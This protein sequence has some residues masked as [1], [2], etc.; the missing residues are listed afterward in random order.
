ESS[1]SVTRRTQSRDSRVQLVHRQRPTDNARGSNQHARGVDVA[2]D[3][4]QSRHLTGVRDAAF[5]H[6]NIRTPRVRDNPAG[7]SRLDAFTGDS[8]GCTANTILREDSTTRAVTV[9]EQKPDVVTRLL[10]VRFDP[11]VDAIGHPAE[12]RGDG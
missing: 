2:G 10:T 11:R 7:Y 6:G 9:R 1:A 3:R 8:D 4:G 5:T 12:R